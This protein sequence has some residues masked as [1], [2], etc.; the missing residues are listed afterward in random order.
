[1]E[2]NQGYTTMHGEPIVKF[3]NCYVGADRRTD[4]P[5]ESS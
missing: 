4:G 5:T 2:I 3:S 1:L